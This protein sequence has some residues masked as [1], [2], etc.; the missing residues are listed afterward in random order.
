MRV[1]NSRITKS[2]TSGTGCYQ[3]DNIIV[4]R[5][6]CTT[7]AGCYQNDNI[8]IDRITCTTG[9]GCYQ[10]VSIF[11]FAD[12]AQPPTARFGKSDTGGTTLLSDT[13]GFGSREKS[14]TSGTTRANQSA[15]F[16]SPASGDF[17]SPACCRAFLSVFF[18]EVS[19]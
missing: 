9:A 1:L 2:H 18:E 12:T 3:S 10:N 6:T 13:G 19:L 7:G 15:F 4:D 11:G 16:S 17:H 14:G 8:I 5:I